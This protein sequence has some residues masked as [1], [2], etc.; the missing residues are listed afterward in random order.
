M[1]FTDCHYST[2]STSELIFTWILCS[3]APKTC[4]VS[5][6]NKTLTAVVYSKQGPLV[7]GTAQKTVL[8]NRVKRGI[9]RK[10]KYIYDYALKSRFK[11]AYV[12]I[13]EQ[14]M[15]DTECSI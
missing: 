11:N 10:C 13:L 4:C 5:C 9:E 12:K 2:A 8:E 3:Q 7:I 1:V 6:C 14:F 15:A